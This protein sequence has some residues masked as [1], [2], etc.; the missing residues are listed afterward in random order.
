VSELESDFETPAPVRPR[1]GRI[2]RRWLFWALLF[3]LVVLDQVVK[4]WS[5][6]AADDV[7]GRTFVTLWPGIFE[8]KLTFNEGI[9][10]GWLQGGGVFLAPV[11]I[12]IALWA[13]W[14]NLSHPYESRWAHA[15]AALLA[16][17]ALG[18]LYDRLF[19][20]QVTDMF[21]FRLIDFPVFNVAD[22]CITVAACMLIISWIR[23]AMQPQG[24]TS[25]MVPTTE[26]SAVS[27]E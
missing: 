25:T 10:F 20:R 4:A 1:T 5:R 27:S 19:L 3:G 16:S 11:A 12:V 14:Y 24:E 23:E 13:V 26:T 21:Y 9:A 18:N 6:H 22:A 2:N 17:G 7:A 15:S 8:L